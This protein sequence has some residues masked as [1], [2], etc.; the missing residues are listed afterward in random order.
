[1]SGDEHDF[2]H[3]DEKS[4]DPELTY[5]AEHEV[6]VGEN[7]KLAR[8]LKGR[9]MQMIAIG[10][11]LLFI[12]FRHVSS[13]ARAHAFSDGCREI[14]VCGKNALVSSSTVCSWHRDRRRGF[15]S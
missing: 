8:Q 3:H 13:V 11:H 2:K 6:Q 5:E 15:S 1:M 4:S 10:M 12:W 7:G 9:H 14:S